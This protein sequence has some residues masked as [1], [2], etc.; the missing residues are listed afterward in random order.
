M[1][2]VFGDKLPDQQTDYDKGSGQK[3]R[4]IIG[5]HS[6][7][8]VHRSIDRFIAQANWRIFYSGTLKVE[9]SLSL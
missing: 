6:L 8:D 7:T 4:Y 2:T 1:W 5:K 9:V 3:C